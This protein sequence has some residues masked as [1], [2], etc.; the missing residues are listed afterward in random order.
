MAVESEKRMKYRSQ[1]RGW[2]R[3][4][5]ERKS[6]HDLAN[7]AAM[8]RLRGKS[9]DYLRAEG[10]TRVEIEN[11]ADRAAT[12]ARVAGE[13]KRGAKEKPLRR[14]EKLRRA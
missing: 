3:E 4:E 6:G 1:E 13:A 10:K 8:G 9:Y 14:G 5:S 7:D 11:A 12:K 2:A